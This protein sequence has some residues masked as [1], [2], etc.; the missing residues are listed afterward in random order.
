MVYGLYQKFMC[1]TW[2]LDKQVTNAVGTATN[3]KSVSLQQP[4]HDCLLI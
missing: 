4:F 2:T 1:V 3:I